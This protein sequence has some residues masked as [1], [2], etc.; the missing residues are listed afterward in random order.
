MDDLSL[1]RANAAMER[2]AGGDEAAFAELYDAIAPRLLRFLRGATRD[3]FA[4]EDLM[5]Q[6]LLHMHRARGSFIPGAPVM[7]W[8]FA[9]ARRLIV[10]RARHSR[11]ERRVFLAPSAAAERAHEPAAVTARP[12]DLAHARRLESRLRQRFEALPEMQRTA[13]RMLR[14]EGRSLEGA[15]G[16]L[17]TS[18]TAVKLRVHRAVTALRAALREAGG[19][20]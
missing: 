7:P 4:T 16:V 20:S 5:Q 17:G 2:Y 9:I 12:D 19:L 10:D 3:A 1:E 18:V 13:Y 15:A 11:V 14:V 6:T 8:A